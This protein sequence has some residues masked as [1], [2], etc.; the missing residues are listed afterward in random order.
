MALPAAI[1]IL[2]SAAPKPAMASTSLDALRD[3]TVNIGYVE[4]T[5]HNGKEE[6]KTTS[7][8]AGV[9]FREPGAPKD[10][11]YL[12]T[13]KH[14]FVNAK[15]STISLR[16]SW[17]HDEPKGT[18]QQILAHLVQDDKRLWR[19]LEGADVACLPITLP[20]SLIGRAKVPTLSEQ[21][22]ATPDDMYVGASVLAIGYPDVV[23][24]W[25][26]AICRQGIIAAVKPTEGAE[27]PFLIDCSIFPGNSGGPVIKVSTGLN[28]NGK[29]STRLHAALLGIVSA[30]GQRRE[31][32]FAGPKEMTTQ[33][34]AGDQPVQAEVKTS[35][36]IVEPASR[37]R[38]LLQ[39][40]ANVK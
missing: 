10:V 1:L 39:Q 29:G 40:F 12:V 22:L 36:G 20:P 33:T 13:A 2:I 35:I 27:N 31:A 23:G 38:R 5:T 21:D 8:G 15:T 18:H 4:S 17:F 3:A 6:P 37:I 34:A 14:V 7:L 32:V 25:D 26:T 24:A 30:A 11:V 19:D 28:R 16:F 9:L